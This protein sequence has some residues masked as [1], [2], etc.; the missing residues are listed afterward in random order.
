M[1]TGMRLTG[2]CAVLLAATV[3]TPT[4]SAVDQTDLKASAAIQTVDVK[5]V[6]VA[7]EASAETR[8]I[9]E[10]EAG[11][12]AAAANVCGA[13]YTISTGAA[14]Y[15]TNGTTYT[16]TNGTTS[17]D[18][19]YDKPICA[20][21]F[22]DTGSA[23]YMGIRLKDNYTDTPHTEDFGTFSTYAGPVY[24]KRG[25]CGEAYSY[26][27]SGSKVVVDNILTVGSCN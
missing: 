23:R 3:V 5:G 19:Y 24:Q 2:V 6:K 7:K 20:V 11:I 22:N 4:A 1:K 25:Y 27:K 15:G 14:R 8:R 13:G 12:A 17:G 26:M 18:R 16:W 21:F 10:A 9:I